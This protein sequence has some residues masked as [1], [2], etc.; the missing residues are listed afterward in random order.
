MYKLKIWWFIAILLLVVVVVVTVNA[1]SVYEK[2]EKP[3]ICPDHHFGNAADP[4]NCYNYYLCVP[5]GNNMILYCA[6]GFAFDRESA[7]CRRVSQ[8]NCDSRPS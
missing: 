8:V 5:G 3:I 1:V 7:T 4:T 6:D 2:E